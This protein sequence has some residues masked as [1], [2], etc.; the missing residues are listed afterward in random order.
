MH[1]AEQLLDAL[2]Y[3]ELY[4]TL[5]S[6]ADEDSYLVD[7]LTSDLSEDFLYMLEVYDLIWI[8]SDER[9][10]LTP[11]GEKVQQYVADIVELS[12][13]SKKIKSYKS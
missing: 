12:K 8:A 11:K 1:S 6:I 13:K 7:Y 5:K 4:Y 9:V 2:S 10:L 3:E